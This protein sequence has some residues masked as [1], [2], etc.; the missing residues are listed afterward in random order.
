MM[1]KTETPIIIAEKCK[2]AETTPEY[3]RL[4]T[5]THITKITNRNGL[6]NLFS[7]LRSLFEDITFHLCFFSS[8]YL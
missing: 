8:Y 2:I 4:N 7:L 6:R 3:K 1:T 5:I